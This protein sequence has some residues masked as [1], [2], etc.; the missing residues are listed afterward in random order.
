MVSRNSVEMR[1]P[2]TSAAGILAVA[3]SI[4]VSLANAYFL[5]NT[6]GL[7]PYVGT[8]LPPAESSPTAAPPTSTDPTAVE[9]SATSSSA[10]TAS[11]PAAVPVV[12]FDVAAINVEIPLNRFGDHDP[13]GRMYVV[14]AVDGDQPA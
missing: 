9:G 3:L 14:T 11:C 12:T 10:V 1:W 6:G 2:A 4:L 5:T 7:T 8:P 13:E